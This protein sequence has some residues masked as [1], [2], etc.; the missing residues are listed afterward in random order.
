M[1]KRS[2]PIET[3]EIPLQWERYITEPALRTLLA[4]SLVVVLLSV[5]SR[6]L[7]AV[8]LRL[9]RSF[10]FTK[11]VSEQLEKPIRV[12][13]PLLGLQAVLAAASDELALIGATRRLTTLLIIACFTWLAMRLLRGLEQAVRLRNPVDVIDNLRARQIQTQSRVL[14]R[15]LGFFVLLIGAAG[16]LMTFPA[17]R[18]F[19]ASLLASAGLAGLAVGFAAR[20]V[21]ANLIAGIQIAITQPIRLDDVVIVENEWGRIEEITGTYVVV[22]IWDDR[23]LVVPLQYFIEKPFQNWTRRNSRIIGSVFFWVDYAMP[24]EP[25]REELRRLC[26]EVPQLWDGRVIVLQVTDTSERSIQLRV[27]VSSPDSSRNWDLRCHLRENLIGFVQR[28]YPHCLPQLR[29]DLSVG[30]KPGVDH[31]VPEH[32][33]PE[34]QPPV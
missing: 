32:V 11:A 18:Q 27:L 17:A 20:P 34:R 2:S 21:L 24:L 33:E 10:L 23:R 8:M 25:L 9:G 22:R 29:A 1:S 19:G 6:V 7:T 30:R 16:M 12:L 26:K 5:F 14:L 4:A 13:L 31:S 15:T 28:Q 3:F